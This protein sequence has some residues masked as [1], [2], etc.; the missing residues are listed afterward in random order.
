MCAQASRTDDFRSPPNRTV[1]PV[2]FVLKNSPFPSLAQ[3]SGSKYRSGLSS[4][5]PSRDLRL[6]P[7]RHHQMVVTG[8]H[9][10]CLSLLA[11]WALVALSMFTDN[12][13]ELERKAD[14]HIF[15]FPSAHA[16]CSKLCVLLS[17]CSTS[18]S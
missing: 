15:R 12:L 8:Q 18:R 11:P 4:G 7:W 5:T 9:H 1:M 14:L 16:L 3:G 2:C 13:Q 17:S 10:A 6:P